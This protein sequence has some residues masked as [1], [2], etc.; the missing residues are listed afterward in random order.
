MSRFWVTLS[1]NE[2]EQH[3]AAD[4]EID[5]PDEV[6]AIAM[7][8]ALDDEGKLKWEVSSPRRPDYAVHVTSEDVL[9]KHW[10]DDGYA[11]GHS[12]NLTEMPAD[13]SLLVAFNRGLDRGRRARDAAMAGPTPPYGTLAHEFPNFDPA[14]LPEIPAGFFPAHW[15]NE[16]CP[17][18]QFGEDAETANPILWIEDADPEKREFHDGKRFMLHWL[19]NPPDS[20]EEW[21]VEYTDDWQQILSAL[22]DLPARVIAAKWV[23][24][25]RL[26]FHPDTR[27]RDYVFPNKLRCLTDAEADEY[28][29]D[30]ERLFSLPGDPYQHGLDA[31]RAAGLLKP[32][33]G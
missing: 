33:E 9:L 13:P 27:G 4:I 20:N 21:C 11:C 7:A 16:I 2:V 25:F 8:K 30:V 3:I 17:R 32:G 5:A 29:A 12:G 6:T 19:A 31:M 28:D 10:E 23:Q 15:H 26:G 24:R 18:W 14:T 1:F 22:A